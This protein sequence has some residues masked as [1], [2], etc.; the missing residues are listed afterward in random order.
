[1]A[2]W[3]IAVNRKT[4]S[5]TATETKPESEKI[6]DRA[7]I[8]SGIRE[9]SRIRYDTRLANPKGWRSSFMTF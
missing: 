1:M 7:D 2:K 8:G 3:R 4:A 5:A 9:T 6:A